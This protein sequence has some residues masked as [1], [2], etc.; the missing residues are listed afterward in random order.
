MLGTTCH[1]SHQFHA[2]ILEHLVTGLCASKNGSMCD[3]F[4]CFCTAAQ[5]Y[6]SVFI[7]SCVVSSTVISQV[8]LN[9][10]ALYVDCFAPFAVQNRREMAVTEA[11]SRLGSVWYMGYST[12][13]SYLLHVFSTRFKR[14]TKEELQWLHDAHG[15]VIERKSTVERS[16]HA[17]SD[18]IFLGECLQHRMK[19]F[20]QVPVGCLDFLLCWDLQLQADA[21]RFLNIRLTNLS[22][23]F[24]IFRYFS[25][26]F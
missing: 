20:M 24:D 16:K 7:R 2:C 17:L 12:D 8:P 10:S 15:I 25:R 6:L 22:R 9:D 23:Y 5:V 1:D 11:R 13:T 18:H 3:M 4:V 19:Q 21:R 26:I 14:S